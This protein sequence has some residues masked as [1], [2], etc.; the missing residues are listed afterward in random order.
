[1]SDKS[2]ADFV[3]K[4]EHGAPAVMGAPPVFHRGRM[5]V[6]YYLTDNEVAA[7]YKY[8]HAYPPKP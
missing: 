2:I 6:F 5:P 1:M 8:L 3:N 7:A 4:V